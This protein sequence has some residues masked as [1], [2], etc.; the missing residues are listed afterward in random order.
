MFRRQLAKLMLTNKISSDGTCPKSPV[1]LRKRG[2]E[3]NINQHAHLTKPKYTGKWDP[4]LG[5][6]STVN[7]KYLK[8]KCSGCNKEVRTH[9]ACDKSVPLCKDCFGKHCGTVGHTY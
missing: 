4:A 5:D 2:R 7:S 9:C 1:R 8:S 6:W 3:S